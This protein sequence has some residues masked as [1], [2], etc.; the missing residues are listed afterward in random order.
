MRHQ[1]RYLIKTEK[2]KI[3]FSLFV[4]AIF[5]I[6]AVPYLVH[7][8]INTIYLKNK[9]TSLIHT[10]TG[11]QIDPYL[12]SLRLFPKPGIILKNFSFTPGKRINLEINQLKIDMDL[13]NFLHG[14][15]VIGEIFLQNP[16]ISFSVPDS[17]QLES[18]LKSRILELKKEFQQVFRFF[19]EDQHKLELTI[20]NAESPYFKRMD[21]SL[22]LLR[23]TNDILFNASIKEFELKTADLSQISLDQYLDIESIA[24]NQLTVTAKIN[25]DFEVQGELKGQSIGI[26]SSNKELIFNSKIIDVSFRLSEDAYQLD[27]KPFK[28]DYPDGVVSVHF[29]SDQTQKKSKIQFTGNNIHIDQAKKMSLS[30]FKNNK[31]VNDLFYILHNGISPEIIVSFEADDLNFLFQA[32]NL[33]LKGKIENGEVKIPGTDLMASKIEGTAEIHKGILDITTSRAQIVSSVIKQGQITINLMGFKHIPFNGAFLLD[34]DLSMVPETMESLLPNTPLAKEMVNVHNITGRSNVS[35]KLSIPIH[36]ND[37]DVKIDSEDFSIKGDYSRIP[38]IISLERI[39]FKYDSRIV[40]LNHIKGTMPGVN[41]E[42]LNTSIDFKEEPAILINSGSGQF[43]LDSL[44]SFLMSNKKIENILLPLKKGS[45]KIDIDSIQLSGPIL[46]PEKW[47]YNITGKGDHLNFTTRLN[48][49]QIENLS[50][51]YHISNNGFSLK[52]L[53][54]KIENLSWLDS[55]F[56]KKYLESFR[57]PLN[58]ENAQLQSSPIKSL[59]YSDLYF[60]DGQKLQLEIEGDS[61]KSLALKKIVILDPGFSDAIITLHP[62]TDKILSY[63]SGILNTK[64]LNKL[65]TPES[66]LEKKLNGFTEGE[67]VLVH[68]DK[69]S[70]IN[71]FTKKINLTSFFS[72]RESFST[73]N[74][75]FSNNTIKLKTEDIIIKNWTIKD[76]DTEILFKDDDAYIRLNNATLCDL[77]EK[78]YIKFI[79]GR[80]YAGI[81][82]KADNKENIQNLLTCLLD[83]TDFMDGRYTV[84]GEL[85]SDAEKKDFLTS[86]KGS[87]FFKAEEGRV[88]KLTL[89][90]RILSV[91]NVSSFFKGSIPD[92]TQKGFAYKM[93]SIE[94]DIKDSIIYITKAIIDGNDMTIIFNGRIDLINNDMDLTCLVAP[95][96]TV[97]LII[98]K[99]P[100]VS[101]LLSGNLVSVPVKAIGKIS[102][103]VVVPL[104]PS[105]IGEG[106]INMMTNILKTPVKLLD[107]I[108]NDEKPKDISTQGE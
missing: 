20:K 76:V 22:S 3:F 84:A 106:L 75:L 33:K 90:S 41:I 78:G 43:F 79:K 9:I 12:V 53:S 45:G 25:S 18:P 38:G 73:K 93:I 65:L 87:V 11:V 102:D 86:L 60:P 37:L 59:V 94:A 107:K 91:L 68:T 42:D 7:F 2:R 72:S 35:L 13:E 57:I 28:I 14:R 103:P 82:F 29:S 88:Y 99:I 80:V 89:L 30:V 56:E 8:A 98:E 17:Q 1:L 83:K 105:A 26:R 27:I 108:S 47:T 48:Q 34:V 31:L 23:E 10:K 96:K 50:C 97:D 19:P 100:I 51:Q 16:K 74:Q 55:L 71:I 69:D 58:I 67:P 49:R 4:S 70:V 44:L 95:F 81:Q 77:E 66:Y 101:T 39:N 62:D 104:H 85:I 52:N 46:Q 32:E 6:I 40:I 64:T 21:G 24:F 5:F 36:S 63:F 54:A 61:L 92:I 15:I